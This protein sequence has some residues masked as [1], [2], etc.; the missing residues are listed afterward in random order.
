MEVRRNHCEIQITT[1]ISYDGTCIASFNPLSPT[2]LLTEHLIGSYH[3]LFACLTNHDE[4]LTMQHHKLAHETI[5]LTP[6]LIGLI[7][8]TIP[9]LTYRQVVLIGLNNYS[10][11]ESSQRGR[12]ALSF[13]VATQS[14]AVF[15]LLIT[16]GADVNQ[17]AALKMCKERRKH[18]IQKDEEETSKRVT[19]FLFFLIFFL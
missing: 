1:R 11:L 14:E 12:T 2:G 9:I 17:P 15:S 3:E 8:G 13:A 6:S 18:L 4:A 7:N 10:Y 5:F 19:V 16:K